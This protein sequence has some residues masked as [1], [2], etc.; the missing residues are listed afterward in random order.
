MLRLKSMH[1]GSTSDSWDPCSK[2]KHVQYVIGRGEAELRILELTSVFYQAK[3]VL[4]SKL[5]GQ[6]FCDHCFS[7]HVSI[8]TGSLTIKSRWPFKTALF[9]SVVLRQ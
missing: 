2:A 8:R 1:F 7:A 4:P 6:N 5:D 3:R 9:F